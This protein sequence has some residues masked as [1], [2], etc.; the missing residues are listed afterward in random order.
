[1]YSKTIKSRNV[2]VVFAYKL[3]CQKNGCWC[4]FELT[5]LCFYDFFTR[6]C[7]KLDSKTMLSEQAINQLV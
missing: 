2:F 4:I 7:F 1:M 6:L 5:K 3:F